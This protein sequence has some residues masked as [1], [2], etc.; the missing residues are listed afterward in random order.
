MTITWKE[1]EHSAVEN[2]V[3]NDPLSLDALRVCGLLNF[4][5]IPNTK[6]NTRLLEMLV[7]YWDSK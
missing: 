4:F 3:M 6:T 5:K 2:E 7:N 1:R